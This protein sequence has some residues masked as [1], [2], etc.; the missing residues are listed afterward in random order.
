LD[1][2]NLEDAIRV[3]LIGERNHEDSKR[4]G[5]AT[6]AGLKRRAER[7]DPVGAVPFGHT[8]ARRLA[9]G[10]VITE[11]VVDDAVIPH[12][13][14]MF[15]R[16][17]AG[18]TSGQVARDLN[19]SGVRTQRGNTWNATAVRGVITN[20]AYKGEKGYERIISPERWQAANDQIKRFDPAAVQARKGGRPAT[21]DY[22]LR[23]VA[24]CGLCRSAL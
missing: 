18:A 14:E 8:T 4:K 20:P 19:A 11:R 5:A 15:A 17:E 2:S 3:V 10:Q 16:I 9:E 1:D 21:G 12:V 13:L 7:G 6:K 24:F 22:L 23:G